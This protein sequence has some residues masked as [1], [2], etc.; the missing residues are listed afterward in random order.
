M[1]CT[2][3]PV[4]C[5]SRCDVC[6]PHRYHVRFFELDGEYLCTWP[7]P[8]Q[9]ARDRGPHVGWLACG[10]GLGLA[11][12]TGELQ[13]DR[14]HTHTNS[15]C[16]T[17]TFAGYYQ[18]ER[19]ADYVPNK[20]FGLEEVLEVKETDGVG[21]DAFA[22]EVLTCDKEQMHIRADSHEHRLDWLSAIRHNQHCIATVPEP[23]PSGTTQP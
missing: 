4:S 20:T 12:L 15:Q 13:H 17:R 16:V 23:E 21:E 14:G 11:W 7:A 2:R 9:P 3:T 18:N 1:H 8:D 6:R 10:L 22:F 5:G 19:S